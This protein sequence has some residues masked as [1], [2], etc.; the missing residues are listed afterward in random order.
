MTDNLSFTPLE[1]TI[2]FYTRN[3]FAIINSLLI[4]NKE[5]LWKMALL[6]YQDNQG[7][8][9][10]YEK[11]IRSI[12]SD[13]DIKWIHSLKKRLIYNLDEKSQ[14][15]I[16]RNAQ[17]DI[18]L[19]LNAMYGSGKDLT[20]YRTAWIDP[21][22]TLNSN[23]PYSREY[24]SLSLSINSCL[25]IQ[26]ISSCSLTPYREEEDVGSNF[27]RYEIFVPKN[28]PILELDPFITHNEDG[29]ILLPPMQCKV[30]DIRPISNSRCRGIINLTY[31][32]PL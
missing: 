1:E 17:N 30:T 13:Y 3:D 27:Y 9:N 24:N 12:T 14:E 7:I 22:I 26:T 28:N 31:I 8:L 16:I 4:D 19:L 23:Y 15:K 29:E 18:H 5:E 11:G 6:A 32:K 20:L 2:S 25:E 21:K 10:E